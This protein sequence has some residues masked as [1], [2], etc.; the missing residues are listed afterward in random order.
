[1]KYL[2][3]VV[4]IVVGFIIGGPIGAAFLGIVAL[5]IPWLVAHFSNRE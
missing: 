1:M 5:S 2:W 3:G 4:G